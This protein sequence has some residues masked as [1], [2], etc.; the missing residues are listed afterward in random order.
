MRT[1]ALQV[2]IT[3]L[4]VCLP[5]YLFEGEYPKIINLRKTVYKN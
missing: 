1:C 5:V 3:L 2:M 4:F